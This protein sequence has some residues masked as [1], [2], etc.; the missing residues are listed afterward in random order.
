M[1]NKTTRVKKKPSRAT[2]RTKTKA[3]SKPKAKP[4]T[5]SITKAKATRGPTAKKHVHIWEIPKRCYPRNTQAKEYGQEVL[6]LT[7]SLRYTNK[8]IQYMAQ[9]CAFIIKSINKKSGF[10]PRRPE[11]FR[12]IEE[13]VYHFENFC[14]RLFTY[15]EKLLQFVNA[16]LPVG[17]SEREV[18]I[19]NILINPTV[20]VSKIL[21]LI[22]KFKKK[23]PL[24][25]LIKDRNALTH[26]LYYGAAF[27]AYF[28]PQSNPDDMDLKDFKSWCNNW[29]REIL[30]RA[31]ATNKCTLLANEINNEMAQKI[32]T[33][34]KK[35]K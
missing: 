30:S 21:P 13:F 24:N 25:R 28:R 5:K 9:V 33:Y 35:D 19:R 6:R 14:Y 15:R 8:N 12:A 18:N 26:K 23:T 11:S 4:R 7:E 2:S 34:K 1:G 29:K 3:K 17:Y 20:K 10:V 27:D 31:T 16:V 22:E 32:I